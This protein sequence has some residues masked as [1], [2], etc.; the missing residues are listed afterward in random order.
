G[1]PGGQPHALPADPHDHG[2]AGGGDDP[3]GAGHGAGRGGAGG[4]GEG[5][6]RR[7][8][9]VAAADAGAD[10]GVLLAV[11]RPRP[12]VGPAAAMRR[13][14]KC[15]VRGCLTGSGVAS[16]LLAADVTSSSPAVSGPAPTAA[17]PD[18]SGPPRTR[19]GSRV[20]SVRNSRGP[21]R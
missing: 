17:W 13:V 10:A 4:D 20:V 9:A 8:D 21:R 19:S 16:P 3:D 6:P 7:A 5:D 18:S 14:R 12:L 1:D 15:P 11:G 2:D